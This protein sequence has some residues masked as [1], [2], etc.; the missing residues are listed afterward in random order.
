MEVPE[1]MNEE[2]KETTEVKETKQEEVQL[3]N[4]EFDALK[5]KLFGDDDE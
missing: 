2:K 3:S 5:K 1:W 4:E